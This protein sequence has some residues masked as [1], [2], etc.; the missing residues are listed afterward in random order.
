MHVPAAAAG[1]TW[2]VR[3]SSKHAC[4]PTTLLLAQPAR[5][6]CPAAQ[7]LLLCC[8]SRPEA[9]GVRRGLHRAGTPKAT[10]GVRSIDLS[11]AL[12]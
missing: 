3:S 7:T 10:G 12:G 8:A 11:H 2:L 9:A 6:E 5:Q 4:R 1:L